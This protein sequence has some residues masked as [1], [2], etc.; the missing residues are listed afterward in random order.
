MSDLELLVRALA[1][2]CAWEDNGYRVPVEPGQ[3]L[4]TIQRRLDVLERHCRSYA[5]S[6]SALHRLLDGR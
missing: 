3:E 2:R 4:A 1:E 6:V 5:R